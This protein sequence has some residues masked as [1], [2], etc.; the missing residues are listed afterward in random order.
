MLTR[1][2]AA[3][4]RR[5]PSKFLSLLADSYSGAQTNWKSWELE[6]IQC[7]A[8][9]N[10]DVL[11]V[12]KDG[13]ETKRV[14]IEA[15]LDHE[16]T[17]SQVDKEAMA[18]DLLFL[19]VLE[20]IDAEDF[21]ARVAGVITWRAALNTFE[22]PRLTIADIDSLPPQKVA[23]ERS[24]RLLKPN[25]HKKLGDNWTVSIDRGGSGMPSIT[26]GSPLLSDGRQLRGQVQVSGR[27]MPVTPDELRFEYRVGVETRPAQSDFPVADDTVEPPLWV[28]HLESLRD[29]VLMGNE[30][31]YRLRMGRS[32]NGRGGLGKNKSALVKKFLTDTPW[33]AAGYY[34]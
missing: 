11:L 3:E 1:A 29:N 8:V 26:C 33:I 21:R 15:K 9:A 5:A 34:D 4:I 27:G 14:G 25:L 6:H 28:A 32:G 10:I 13:C 30:T 31:R 22:D 18:V 20:D 7:D 17:T 2:L 23:I 16:L 12:L 19:L 24:F